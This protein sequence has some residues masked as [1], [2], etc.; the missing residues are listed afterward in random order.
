MQSMRQRNGLTPHEAAVV[1][2]LA[3]ICM[4]AAFV[5]CEAPPSP[6]VPKQAVAPKVVY[7]NDHTGHKAGA[8]PW[9][10]GGTCTCTPSAEL[11][12]KL[13]AD[14]FCQGMSADRLRA[15][16]EKQGIALRGDGH[17][18]CNGMCEAGPHVVLGGRCMCP[19]TPGT[20]YYEKVIT[21]KGAPPR[22]QTVAVK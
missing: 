15:M 12:R 2:A 1:V 3:G 6:F 21:G 11:M 14:G 20:E 19:P 18:W 7:C 17:M 8:K 10:M 16:Y 22:E 9:I 13:Q 5:G 4:L